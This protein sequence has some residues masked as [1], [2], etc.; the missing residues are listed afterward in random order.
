MFVWTAESILLS[1]RGP[2]LMGLLLREG[3]MQ[4]G[5]NPGLGYALKQEDMTARCSVGLVNNNAEDQGIDSAPLQAKKPSIVKK[6]CT[7]IL[8]AKTDLW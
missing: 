6:F 7:S 3:L 8:K 5:L 4:A 2:A 1:L